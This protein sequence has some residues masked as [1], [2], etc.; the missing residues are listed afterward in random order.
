MYRFGTDFARSSKEMFSALT[1]LGN[2]LA[3]LKS[4]RSLYFPNSNFEQVSVGMRGIMHD[5]DYSGYHPAREIAP[6]AES[7]LLLNQLSANMNTVEK[8]FHH[9]FIP[10]DIQRQF[11]QALFD[12]IEGGKVGI[13]E[14]PTGTLL[15]SYKWTG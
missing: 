14:S 7:R 12:C 2:T 1:I 13:F 11:M 4:W 10:Y 9:P 3:R 5:E 15:Y 6:S 8:N